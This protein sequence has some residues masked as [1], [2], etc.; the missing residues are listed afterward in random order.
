MST[1]LNLSAA[2][3]FDP[4]DADNTADVEYGDDLDYDYEPPMPYDYRQQWAD[5]PAQWAVFYA[6]NLI[7]TF[8]TVPDFYQ[9]LDEST[10]EKWVFE[11][12][13]ELFETLSDDKTLEEFRVGLSKYCRM[14]KGAALL[15]NEILLHRRGLLSPLPALSPECKEFFPGWAS[16]ILTEPEWSWHSQLP[17]PIAE[18]RGRWATSEF[19]NPHESDEIVPH[20]QLPRGGNTNETSESRRSI[21]AHALERD[22]FVTSL[23]AATQERLAFFIS[24]PVDVDIESLMKVDRTTL[25][26]HESNDDTSAWH[27]SFGGGVLS[28]ALLEHEEILSRFRA[29]LPVIYERDGEL[30]VVEYA[31]SPVTFGREFITKAHVWPPTVAATAGL[32][33]RLVTKLSPQAMRISRTAPMSMAGFYEAIGVRYPYSA[34]GEDD[35]AIPF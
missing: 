6:A 34:V 24:L 21:T 32:S 3:D 28:I 18:L 7:R 22:D 23:K 5:N 16:R 19:F 20:S 8:G 26:V 14:L 12:Y 31:W 17:G 13:P 1:D 11:D 10:I 2:E 4:R 29:R 15:A 30:L 25:A 9:N 35:D 33:P 27:L